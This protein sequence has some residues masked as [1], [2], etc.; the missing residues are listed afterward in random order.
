MRATQIQSAISLGV[1]I[2]AAVFPAHADPT[3]GAV[4]DGSATIGVTGKTTTITQ[5]TDKA[6]ID[7]QAF[8][9]ASNEK[10]N[11]VQPSQVAITLNR[12]L[13]PGS[14]IIDGQIDAD[15]RVFII[16]GDGVIFGA[17]AK[18]DVSGL[19]VSSADISNAN[20]MSG[21]FVFDQPGSAN[22]AI[23]NIGA[24]NAG[25]AG[26]IAFV[27]PKVQNSG[28]LKARFG[29][30]ALAS[31]EAFTLDFF[32]DQLIVFAASSAAGSKSGEILVNGAIEAESGTILLTATSA[33]DFVDTVI[34]VEADL[35]A[36]S[37]SMQGGRIILT[38][39]DQSL[40]I[41]NATIDATGTPGG[42]ISVTGG[43]INVTANGELLTDAK[44]G[45][46]DGGDIVVHSVDETSFA[47]LASSEPGAASG[48]GGD[49][50]IGSDGVLI[51]TGTARAGTPPR[52]GTISLNGQ[53][54]DDGNT[55][56][57]SGGGGSGG[58]P[59]IIVPGPPVKN[60]AADRLA[61]IANQSGAIYA[62]D[63]SSGGA[64]E[65]GA[66]V[67]VGGDVAFDFS[68]AGGR[69]GDGDEARLM[70]LHGVSS[71]ACGSPVAE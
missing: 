38:G 6:I 5:M 14:S 37:A 69:S 56:G 70:C 8:N 35:V 55:G 24:I 10:V 47:G 21:N 57:G 11:F 19:L 64:R 34:N 31:G 12:V 59:P 7:W 53:I 32:G 36:R 45:L 71:A 46:A 29:K 67:L 48:V 25:D 42:S 30:V 17:G 13:G 16:N 58:G 51:F 39:G 33:R 2:G 4:I 63:E 18:I 28:V 54:D 20:F 26:M 66:Q 43:E 27:A 62:D 61:E 52:A 1:L 15:G 44:T 60:E 50:A 23:I 65:A 40:I 3:G 49:I 68:E 9:I 41:I 22:A